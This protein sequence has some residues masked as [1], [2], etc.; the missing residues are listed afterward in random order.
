MLVY[1]FGGASVK[2]A[3]AV[4]Q[5][6]NIVHGC[7]ENLIVVISAMGKTTNKLENVLLHTF[8][9]DGTH[10]P[11]ISDL[12]TFHLSLIDELLPGNQEMIDVVEKTFLLIE[13]N[14]IK[15]QSKGYDFAYDQI[16][17][18][19][20]L[21]STKIVSN[22]LNNEGVSNQWID[23]REIFRTDDNY[24]DAN[25]LVDKTEENAL[26]NFD[27][28]SAQ[29]YITQGFIASD[30]ENNTTTLGREGSDYSAA[31]LASNLKADT[32]TLWKDVAGIYNADPVLF[33]EVVLLHELNYQEM[34]EMAF[35][36]AKVIHPKTIKPIKEAG[37]SLYVKCFYTPEKAG[38]VVCGDT[39]SKSNVP[40]FIIKSN[41][42]LISISLRD[43][44]FVSEND[45][46]KLFNLLNKFRLKANVIQHSAISFSVCVD[47]PLGKEIE[48]LIVILKEDFKVLY[49]KDLKLQTIRN[50]AEEDIH[51]MVVGKKIFIE[52]RSRNT[53]QFVSD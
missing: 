28:V 25:I 10:L 5:L 44:S 43:L 35:Y 39:F 50:Y 31:L 12:K 45:I 30:L 8:K 22:Y 18:F 42:V 32:V 52:Q 26:K 34:I 49:N 14:C 11:L 6:K 3:S 37:I 48:D 24:R 2:D 21:L 38:T 9:N 15:C 16:V 1:K 36:G 47:T 20:E 13:E 19:G 17:S 4:R 40:I 7:K 53:V 23:I 41:Q 27:F 33:D 29:I 51:Q 46:S